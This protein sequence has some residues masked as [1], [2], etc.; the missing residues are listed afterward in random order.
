MRAIQWL[1]TDLRFGDSL[2]FHFSG[3][4]SQLR[5]PTG[6]EDDGMDET[7]LPADHSTAGQI[8]DTGERRAVL[9]PK[10]RGAPQ[11]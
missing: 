9:A 10:A 2:F 5:D 11:P 6:M 4:G 8:R 1:M 3:H 7:I